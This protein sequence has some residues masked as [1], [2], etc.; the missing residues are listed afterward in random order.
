MTEIEIRLDLSRQCGNSQHVRD[1]FFATCQRQIEDRFSQSNVG[2]D[3]PMRS[4]SNIRLLIRQCGN[5][6]ENESTSRRFAK[7]TLVSM[8]QHIFD[9]YEKFC[10]KNSSCMK[11][12]GSRTCIHYFKLELYNI[13][14]KNR[15]D[16]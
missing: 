8:Y 15:Q 5:F 10:E 14:F 12:N 6:F 16:E 3:F 4:S 13:E 11:N 2:K 1:D 7:H 9:E